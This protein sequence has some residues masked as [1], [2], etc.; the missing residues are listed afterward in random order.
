MVNSRTNSNKR[1][2]TD[3][4][5]Q[6]DV[7]DDV[8][9]VMTVIRKTLLTKSLEIKRLE[10]R[11]EQ[12]SSDSSRA[13]SRFQQLCDDNAVI[14]KVNEDQAEQIENYRLQLSSIRKKMEKSISRAEDKCKQFSFSDGE[15]DLLIAW[16]SQSLAMQK[17]KTS[18]QFRLFSLLASKHEPDPINSSEFFLTDHEDGDPAPEVDSSCNQACQTV[19]PQNISCENENTEPSQEKSPTVVA[20]AATCEE[21]PTKRSNPSREYLL[22]TF[23]ENSSS[24]RYMHLLI[25]FTST[26]TEDKETPKDPKS[27]ENWKQELL[28][29]VTVVKL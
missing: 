1:A 14:G 3:V 5:E 18:S 13:M 29:A 21:Q 8:D 26:E 15:K 27:W 22:R 10:A 11:L 4:P 7:D 2:R 19:P 25:T 12:M 9:N 20:P 17:S 28:D 6:D 23:S 24:T 16:I